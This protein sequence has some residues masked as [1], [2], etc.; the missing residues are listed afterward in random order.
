MPLWIFGNGSFDFDTLSSF[1]DFSE[2]D[3]RE[4]NHFLQRGLATKVDPFVFVCVSK[5]ACLRLRGWPIQACGCAGLRCVHNCLVC[6][7][8][9]LIAT[10]NLPP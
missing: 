10:A 9:P 7:R 4:V 6:G 8:L 1:A 2:W 3:P 5:Q